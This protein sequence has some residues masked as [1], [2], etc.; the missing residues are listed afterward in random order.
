[1]NTSLVQRLLL[2]GVGALLVAGVAGAAVHQD[3]GDDARAADKRND[4]APRS[5]TAASL[6]SEPSSTSPAAD[7]ALPTTPST[8][9]L[10]PPVPLTGASDA[11]ATSP[12]ST[13]LGSGLAA[14][15]NGSVASGT[16][17]LAATGDQPLALPGAVLL[18]LGGASR[19]VLRASNRR[20]A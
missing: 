12:D 6:T 1:M 16:A 5:G 3:D 13:A 18:M 20:P 17:P 2:T 19:V 9:L 10:E 15:G 11:P 8:T 14:S 4:Q 7:P